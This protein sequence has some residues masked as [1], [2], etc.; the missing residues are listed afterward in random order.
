MLLTGTRKNEALQACWAEIDDARRLWRIPSPK[1][2]RRR[3]VPLSDAV[4][5][6]LEQIGT[7]EHSPF[8]FPNP[9]TGKPYT[10]IQPAWDRARRRAGLAEV[11]LHELRHSYAS[12][13]VNSGHSIYEVERLLG[14][15]QI[16]TTQRY[17][18]L[19]QERLLE[20]SNSSTVSC[21]GP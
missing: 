13:L 19:S 17:A 12:L 20:A 3:H 11:R 2:G 7:R 1:G 16:R 14:H 4:L 9:S 6:L 10:E 5:R 21:S 18:H 8:L 15:T